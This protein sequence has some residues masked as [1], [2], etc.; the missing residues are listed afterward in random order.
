LRL[1]RADIAGCKDSKA[2]PMHQGT[3]PHT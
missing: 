3:A 2:A 1:A